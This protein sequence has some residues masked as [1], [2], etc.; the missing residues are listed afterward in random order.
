MG[1][2]LEALNAAL[3]CAE[4]LGVA[5]WSWFLVF[6]WWFFAGFLLVFGVFLELYLVFANFW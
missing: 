6:S 5:A 4:A 2:G 1:L 3:S